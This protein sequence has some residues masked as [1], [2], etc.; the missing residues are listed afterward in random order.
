MLVAVEPPAHTD[1]EESLFPWP[2][3]AR[4]ML[5]QAAH[6]AGDALVAVALAGT[7]FFSV[8]TNQARTHV[9]LYLL[10]TMTPF[11]LLSPVV[12]RTLT[13]TDPRY[14]ATF[15]FL[16]FALISFMRAQFNVQVDM[17]TLMVPTL[18]QGAA[19]AEPHVRNAR[20]RHGLGH[21]AADF[22]FGD[23]ARLIGDQR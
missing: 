6:A 19:V 18:L 3:F 4:M 15:S 12:G 10:L 8:S 7:L 20:P 9:G 14:I 5:A 16:M 21:V 22:P 2:P 13:H 23:I 17:A 1:H 11:A